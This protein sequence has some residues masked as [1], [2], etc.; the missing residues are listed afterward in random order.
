MSRA[1]KNTLF[2][3]C[4]CL[5]FCNCCY[6]SCLSP[7]AAASA[8]SQFDGS[9][10]IYNIWWLCAPFPVLSCFNYPLLRHYIREGYN[11]EGNATDDCMTSTF[12]TPCV[13]TQLLNEVSDRGIAT[14]SLNSALP[15]DTIVETEYL[16]DSCMTC[17]CGYCEVA[18]TVADISGVVSSSRAT[19]VCL[20]HCLNCVVITNHC[21]LG[22]W[23][24]Y[25]L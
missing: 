24:F 13:I 4:C 2:G 16:A 20:S 21:S 23:P 11:I 10:W 17:A 9:P 5:S 22:G 6:G 3:D 12:C 8:K 19:V 25:S 18:S 7:C 15:A 1:W 14:V